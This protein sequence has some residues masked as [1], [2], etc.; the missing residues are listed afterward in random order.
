MDQAGLMELDFADVRYS[1]FSA[2][3]A[4]FPFSG[5]L[6]S[7]PWCWGEALGEGLVKERSKANE[8][9]PPASPLLPL[10]NMAAKYFLVSDQTAFIAEL[11]RYQP[12]DWSDLT[13]R[14]AGYRALEFG[15]NQQALDLFRRTSRKDPK[16]F[17]A[18]AL[19]SL[20]SEEYQQTEEILNQLTR[21][22][23]KSLEFNDLLILHGLLDELQSHQSLQVIDE[24]Y[25]ADLGRNLGESNVP[26]SGRRISV[27]TFCTEGN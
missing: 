10:I 9:L 24:K 27:A 12:E 22:K 25:F 7:K 13:R 6:W 26:A 4:N 8:I 15:M 18:G 19:A 17:L 20:R 16:D 14:F 2:E 3:Q 11:K 1:L 23:W 21:N 5:F